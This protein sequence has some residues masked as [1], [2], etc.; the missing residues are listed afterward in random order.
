MEIP[1]GMSVE[2]NGV[3]LN[4]LVNSALLI[5]LAAFGK[6]LRISGGFMQ[7]MK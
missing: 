5:R 7:K 1:T 3:L 2:C 6:L 4:I